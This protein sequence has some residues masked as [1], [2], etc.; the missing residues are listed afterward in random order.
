[1]QNHYLFVFTLM[2]DRTSSVY[3][4]DK[5]EVY[6]NPNHIRQPP[7]PAERNRHIRWQVS[8]QRTE[9]RNDY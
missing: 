1:M 2:W 8:V 7:Q 3:L 9:T 5:S 6:H 4:M